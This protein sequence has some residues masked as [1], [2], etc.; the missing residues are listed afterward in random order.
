MATSHQTRYFSP[1][2]YNLLFVSFLFFHLLFLFLLILF[3]EHSPLQPVGAGEGAI[4]PRKRP[5]N[6]CERCSRRCHQSGSVGRQPRSSRTSRS[7]AFLHKVSLP[8]PI[9]SLSPWQI[10]I[11]FRA[12]NS[13]TFGSVVYA[14]TCDGSA[15]QQFK[16]DS[17]AGTI[18]YDS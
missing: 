16:F 5:A 12:Q 18:T 13:T 17:S 15:A 8:L 10:L 14:D 11:F 6:C 7:Q 4:G 9:L 3:V 2:S 1:T